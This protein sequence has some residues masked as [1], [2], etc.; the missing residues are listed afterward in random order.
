MSLLETFLGLTTVS[1]MT[2]GDGLS[3]T[4]HLTTG[5]PSILVTSEMTGCGSLWES[6]FRLALSHPLPTQAPLTFLTSLSDV[7]STPAP[8]NMELS[9]ATRKSSL[10]LQ[11]LQVPWSQYRL[12]CLYLDSDV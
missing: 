3:C 9:P 1:E 8:S 5:L 12:L 2:V 6:L 11:K 7:S 10:T 4:F